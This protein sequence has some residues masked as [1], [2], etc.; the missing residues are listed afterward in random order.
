MRVA[1]RI[2]SGKLDGFVI[3]RTAEGW[4]ALPPFFVELEIL[5]SGDFVTVRVG[6]VIRKTSPQDARLARG[7][8]SDFGSGR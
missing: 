6:H 4:S 8:I 1:V 5:E 3:R 7:P 2:E